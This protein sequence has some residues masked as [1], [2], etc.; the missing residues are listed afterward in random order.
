M[1]ATRRRHPLRATHHEVE[2]LAEIAARGEDARTPVILLGAVVFVVGPVV[3]CVL[4]LALAAG[5][6]ASHVGSSTQ[7]S[8]HL[9][10]HATPHD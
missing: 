9:R 2:H 6:V 8:A 7:E 5:F 3:T 1:D 10:G 4:A